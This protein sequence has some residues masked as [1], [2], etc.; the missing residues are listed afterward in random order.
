MRTV[1]VVYDTVTPEVALTVDR[2]PSLRRL[3]HQYLRMHSTTDHSPAAITQRQRSSHTDVMQ[4]TRPRRPVTETPM[5]IQVD[6]ADSISGARIARG[7]PGAHDKALVL[8]FDC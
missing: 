7:A 6:E 4:Q 3:R 1:R 5:Q 8:A 2:A